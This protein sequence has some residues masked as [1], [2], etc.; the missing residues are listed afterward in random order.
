MK[1]WWKR[2][3]THRDKQN[4]SVEKSNKKV[5]FQKNFDFPKC[6]KNS[7]KSGPKLTIAR[8]ARNVAKWHLFFIDFQT[9]WCL[10]SN[11][12]GTFLFQFGFWIGLFLFKMFY[13]N[14]FEAKFCIKCNGV[15]N[16]CTH[17][18]K[19]LWVISLDRNFKSGNVI[20]LYLTAII[21]HESVDTVWKQK[22][23][24]FW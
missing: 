21:I 10:L 17:N 1:S 15:T 8:S 3:N 2:E 23:N 13:C 16:N 4:H 6:V 22:W 19:V 20:R 7:F 11:S 9:L 12:V 24:M 18:A 5:S 14:V